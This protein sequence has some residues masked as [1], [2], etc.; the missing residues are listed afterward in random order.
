MSVLKTYGEDTTSFKPSRTYRIV[1]DHID[2]KADGKEAVIQAIELMLSTERWRHLVYSADY[3]IEL[4]E[5]FGKARPFVS[6]DMQRRI[7]EAL[8]QDDR[9]TS[10]EDFDI[11]F[12]GNTAIISC[13][14]VTIFGDVSVERG[15]TIG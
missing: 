8:L 5:L 14:A 12:S 15:V 9:I 3:G 11:S 1:G 10:V 6:A 2:G 13:T 7:S 4:E